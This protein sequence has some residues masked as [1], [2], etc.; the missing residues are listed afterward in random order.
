MEHWGLGV[1][2]SKSIRRYP[3]EPDGVAQRFGINA[4]RL[5][6]PLNGGDVG[7]LQRCPNVA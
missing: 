2:V 7:P 4:R 3:Q 5:T 6:S 1:V